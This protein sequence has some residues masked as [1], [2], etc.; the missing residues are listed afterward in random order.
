MLLL[1]VLVAA[2][3]QMPITPEDVASGYATRHVLV[4]FTA[5]AR[6]TLLRSSSFP[7][8]LRSTHTLGLPAGVELEEPVVD[9]LLRRSDEAKSSVPGLRQVGERFLYLRLPSGVSAVECVTRLRRNPHVEYCELDHVGQALRTIPNDTL[10][11]QQW[12]HTNTISTSVT[13][14]RL[15]TPEAWDISQGSTNIQVAVLDSGIDWRLRELSGRVLAGF[16]FVS[17]SADTMD[18]TGHGTTVA[19]LLAANANNHEAGAGID[20]NCRLLPVKIIDDQNYIRESWVA[21]GVDYAVAQGAKVINFSGGADQ[22][23][24]V[25]LGRAISNAIAQGVIFVCASG[26]SGAGILPFP[27]SYESAIAVGASTSQDTRAP[28]SNYGAQL[29]LLAPGLSVNTIHPSADYPED[30]GFGFASGTSYAAPMVSGVCSL[31]AAVRPDLTQEQ[32]MTLLGAGAQDQLGDAPGRSGGD[33]TDT[34]G[35]DERHGWGRV[36]AYFSLL[37]ATTRID[38]VNPLPDGRLELSWKSPINASTNRPF[39][40]EFSTPLT[41]AWTRVTNGVFRYEGYRTWW[42]E[43]DPAPTP[44]AE[45]FYRVQIVLE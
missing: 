15:F 19:G 21:Q 30:G 6:G 1:G 8:S 10:F 16:N 22:D 27:A 13:R 28:S 17:N 37:L 9:S 2:V 39:R 12:H 40:V 18:I 24:G 31:M 33:G 38:Q 26:N 45:R 35:W 20:W 23:G 5:Q 4:K 29:D 43:P 7:T 42:N 3:A 32:A 41:N 36:N 11:W 34:P 25:T 44:N 14:G